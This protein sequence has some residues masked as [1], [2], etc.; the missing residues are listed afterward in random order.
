MAVSIA[1]QAVTVA[2]AV[3]NMAVIKILFVADFAYPLIALVAVLTV[4]LARRPSSVMLSTTDGMVE[5][6][7]ASSASGS[8][9]S[10][11]ARPR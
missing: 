3:V 9:C 4:L 1:V 6:R 8:R 10:R 11:S 2:V 7:A 5:I